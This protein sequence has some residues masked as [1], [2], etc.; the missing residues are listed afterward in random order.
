MNTA[1]KA[2]ASLPVPRAIN[3]QIRRFIQADVFQPPL[4]DFRLQQ[5]PDY[6]RDF[7]ASR[8]FP[9]KLWNVV[10]QVLM[11][12]P[13]RHFAVQNSFQFIKVENHSSFRIRLARN[14][15]FEDVVVAM[16]LRIIALAKYAAILLRGQLRIMIEVRRG[17]FEFSRNAKHFLNSLAAYPR[18][19]TG[20]VLPLQLTRPRL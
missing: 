19:P 6:R 8:Y 15:H 20:Y 14:R 16:T 9:R 12:H 10:I 18:P 4:P 5:V 2:K 11:I 3:E 13:R 17:K 1:A 7:L